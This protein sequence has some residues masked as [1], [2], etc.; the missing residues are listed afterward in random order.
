MGLGATE[1]YLAAGP[2]QGDAYL[3]D[4]AQWAY[5][6][7]TGKGADQDSFNLYD[8]AALMDAELADALQAA[9]VTAPGTYRVGPAHLLGDLHDQ[10]TIGIGGMAHDPF[11]LADPSRWADTASHALGYAIT[12]RLYDRVAG[13]RTYEAFGQHQ[14]DWAL[15]TNAWGSSFVVG[16]GSVF[17]HCL[18]HQVANLAGSLSGRGPILAG[19]TVGGPTGAANVRQ[20]GAPDGYRRCP[21]RGADP[22]AQF[23][24]HRAAYRDDVRSAATS[25]PTDDASA[26]AL[27]AFSLWRG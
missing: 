5:A 24:G 17:P 9:G 14:L 27:L 21:A 7:T 23:D 2:A 20:L 3:R 22:F 8:V 26:L 4:A 13:G 1:L 19:A 25:E 18:Q 12:A 10:L 16:A 11:A 15:G 6:Y